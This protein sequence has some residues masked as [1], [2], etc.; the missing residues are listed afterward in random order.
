MVMQLATDFLVGGSNPAEVNMPPPAPAAAPKGYSARG[1]IQ[2]PFV[3]H[4]AAL[5]FDQ[6]L[7]SRLHLPHCLEPSKRKLLTPPHTHPPPP[8]QKSDIQF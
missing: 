1:S 2:R 8:P 6:Q 4:S 5:P 3:M 7:Y